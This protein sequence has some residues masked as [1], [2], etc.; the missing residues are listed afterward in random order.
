M[1]T[2]VLAAVAAL[3]APAAAQLRFRADGTFKI[4]EVS[5]THFT[6][7][8]RCN[9]LSA[10]QER[11]PCSDANATAFW[12][13]L[14]EAEA[15][16]VFL[17]TGDAGTSPAARSR[18]LSVHPTKRN[19]NHPHLTR[20]VCGGDQAGGADALEGLLADWAPS[21]ANAHVPWVV[22]EGVRAAT[23][24]HSATRPL[25]QLPLLPF[26]Q[27]HDGESGLNYAQVAAKLLTMPN[28]LNEPSPTFN[29]KLIYGNTNFLISVLGTSGSPQAAH[30][31][32]SLYFV[33]SNSYSTQP[34]V[35]G[36]GW[37]HQ[38]QIVRY[39]GGAARRAALIRT[40]DQRPFFHHRTTS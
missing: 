1:R 11:Y 35:S 31:K 25:T 26:T 40:T 29:G 28:G 6:R 23:T 21:G 37:V 4:V 32:L 19:P 14:I 38:D 3:V 12:R 17:F 5:D 18:A 8:H 33:D 10:A 24:R 16:D 9:D 30:S 7:N 15:P 34:G 36:Y 13:T 22:V 39:C 20:T 2:S 27:N